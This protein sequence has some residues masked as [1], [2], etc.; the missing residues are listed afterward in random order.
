MGERGERGHLRPRAK[1]QQAAGGQ[2]AAGE[3]G[4]IGQGQRKVGFHAGIEPRD[5][6]GQRGAV[7][8]GIDQH[9]DPAAA[10]QPHVKRGGPAPEAHQLPLALCRGPGQRGLQAAIGQRAD[11]SPIGQHRQLGPQPPRPAAVDRHH[12]AQRA[13]VGG[14]RAQGGLIIVNRQCRRVRHHRG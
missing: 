7:G 12:C 6:F 13:A 2:S 5:R 11:A 10:G 14:D 3:A 1:C 8:R 4:A 9:L